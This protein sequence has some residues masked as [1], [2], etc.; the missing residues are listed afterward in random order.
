ML[1]EILIAGF[2]WVNSEWHADESSEPCIHKTLSES[3]VHHSVDYWIEDRGGFG[4]DG[5]Y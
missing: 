1:V 2:F 3:L 4:D 5:A